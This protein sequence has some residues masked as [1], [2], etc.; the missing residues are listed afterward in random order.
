M[1]ARSA[2]PLRVSDSSVLHCEITSSGTRCSSCK[3]VVL[4]TLGGCH[5]LDGLVVVSIEACKEDRAVLQRRDCEGYCAH[6]AG[7][8]KSNSS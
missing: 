6:P 8:A 5:L 3:P 1:L 4:V 7:A 2:N